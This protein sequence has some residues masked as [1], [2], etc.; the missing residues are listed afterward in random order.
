M[1]KIIGIVGHPSSGKDT[2]AGYLVKKA[3]AHI[4][5]GDILREEMKKHGVPI[6]RAS[7]QKFVLQ[8][9]KERGG[10]YLA[11]E[12]I[13]RVTGDTVI[14]GF[15]NTAEIKILKQ[16]FGNSFFLIAVEA[17]VE[18]RYERA[19]ARNRI[20]DNITFEM[21]KSQEDTE[22]KGD[23]NTF[24]VDAVIGMA[25]CLVQNDSTEV[26]LFKKIDACLASAA[27]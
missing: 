4:S 2:A 12:S 23:P 24:D 18:V 3:Y 26:E 14:S 25:D 10:G 6:D 22:R 21:F 5:M 27:I 20:G 13:K 8:A 9:R 16:E 15:R 11:E 17:P 7:G 19:K 1:K